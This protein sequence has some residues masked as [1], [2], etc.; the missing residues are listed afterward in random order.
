M[1]W[2]G[3]RRTRRERDLE[4]ELRDH[5]ALEA[6]DRGDDADAARRALG[7]TL[8]IRERTRDEWPWMRLMLW[9]EHLWQ[10]VRHGIRVLVNAPGFMAV[11]VLSIACGTGANVA[12]FSVADAL[13]LRPLPVPQPDDLLVV[14]SRI[15]RG[16]QTTPVSYP[17]YLDIRERS[18][19]FEGVLAYLHRAAGVR[20]QPE[21]SPLVRIVT[22]VSGNFFDVL[23]LQPAAGRWFRPDEDQ[24]PGRDAVAVMSHD[25]WQER[26][27]GDPSAVGRTLRINDVEFTIVGVAPEGFAGLDAQ[28]MTESVYAPLA[29]TPSLGA[30][31]LRE[32]LTDRDQRFLAL[33]GRLRPGESL[34][35][36]RADLAVIGQD[37]SRAYPGAN[38]DRHL[39]AQTEIEARFARAP[40]DTGLLLLL[41]ILSTAVL[42]VACANVAGLLASRAPLRAREMSLRLAIGAGRARLVRQ[43]VTESLLLALAGG[44]C[45]LGVGLAAIT[46]LRQIRFPT[47]MLQ[48][49]TIQLDERA[50]AFNLAVAMGSAFLFGLGPA[51]QTSCVDLAG[52]IRST[53]ADRSPRWYSARSSLVA[54]QVALS[55]VIVTLA[56]FVSQVFGQVVA[57]GPGFRTTQIAKVTLDTQHRQYTWTETTAFLERALE[58]VRQQPNVVSSALT[59][60]MPLFEFSFIPVVPEGLR[61]ADLQAG[62]APVH[63]SVDEGY[64]DTMDIPVVQGRGFRATDTA[65]A[66]RVAVVNETLATRYWPGREAVGARFRLGGD[67]GPWVEVVGV[68]RDA[69]YIHVAESPLAAV[70]FPFRQRPRGRVTLLAATP[71]SS[72]DGIGSLREVVR[73]LDAD[74][75]VYD[76]QTIETYYEARATG[77]LTVATEMVA[78]IGTMGVL[79]T[80]VG[81]YALVAYAGR[82]RTREIG[83]RMAVGATHGRVLR[84]ILHQG[85][86]PAWIGLA[87]GVVLS[88]V[89]ARL[90]PV[91]LPTTAR[92]DPLTYAVAM[93]ILLALTLLAS[94]LPARRAALVDPVK[95]LRTE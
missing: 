26:F 44:V 89:V 71:G 33:R 12:M 29:M 53:G 56:V 91:L 85:M 1:S 60:S 13:I 55:L 93:P 90:L 21:A 40:L 32:M 3:R 48:V 72:I 78:G 49:P 41:T 31:G 77:I 2:P 58:G 20:V 62:T 28:G 25:F 35:T 5:L 50:L 79:L 46:V 15:E 67:D 82:R 92:Y 51:L 47:E 39:Q 86:R 8:L 14:S 61:A 68:A 4:R 84:M 63:A 7:N 64:F 52:A 10:D 45:G 27:G 38:R 83:I 95:A 87:T 65:G 30:L 70:Y 16:D 59:S 36:A 81:L 11:A 57:S 80:M 19:S 23:R 73:S 69:T 43:L 88:V 22:L 18:R 94:F 24:V 17:D 34:E 6:E 66:P 74:M 76:A 9:L 54:V 37:L 42:G 75:P